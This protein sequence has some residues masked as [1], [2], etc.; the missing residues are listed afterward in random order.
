VVYL[1]ENTSEKLFI[2]NGDGI[3]SIVGQTPLKTCQE[4][5]PGLFPFISVKNG[6]ESRILETK[7]NIPIRK[8]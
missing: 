7:P 5:A 2:L 1:L 8:H 4:A 6:K 3:Y